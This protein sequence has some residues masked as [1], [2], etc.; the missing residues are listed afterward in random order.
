[1]S[2]TAI[3]TV[4]ANGITFCI[5]GTVLSFIFIRVVKFLNPS[6]AEI[7]IIPLRASFFLGDKGA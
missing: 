1:M 2:K 5:T 6:M 3:L 7:T 4:F